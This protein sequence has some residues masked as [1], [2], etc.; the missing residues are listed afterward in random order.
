MKAPSA[1]RDAVYVTHNEI[2]VKRN[3]RKSFEQDLFKLFKTPIL[4]FRPSSRSSE[5]R[6]CAKAQSDR[7]ALTRPSAHKSHPPAFRRRRQS[8]GR[9][10][11][12]WRP[13]EAQ[14]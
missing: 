10:R 13:S 11:R 1:S 3:P 4:K 8:G 14:A 9:L 12:T 5:E 2:R 7:T 6:R